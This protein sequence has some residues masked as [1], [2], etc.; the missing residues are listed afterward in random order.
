MP[1]QASTPT[2]FPCSGCGA[3]LEFKPGT[4][5]LVCPHCGS[6]TPI[7]P[8]DTAVEE[9]DYEATL[10]DLTD[11]HDA[12][13]KIVVHCDSCGANVPMEPNVTS[14]ACPFCG[15]NIVATGQSKRLLRPRSLLPFSLGSEQAR[16]RFA[17]WINGLWF[18]PSDLKRLA[19]I[20]RVALASGSTS[21]GTGAGT[22]L[23][24][25]YVPYWTFDSACVTPYTGQRGD[26]YTVPVTYTVSVNGRSQVRTRLETRIR[27]SSASGCV[28]DRF[29][30]VLVP[31]STSLPAD[32]LA[33]LGAWDLKALVPY[34]D[35]YLSGFRAESYTIDLPAGFA[36][37]KVIMIEGIKVTIRRDIGGDHQRIDS[38]SPRFSGITFK[39]ILLPVWISTFRY[40]GT[41]YRFLVNARTG[42]VSGQ[43]PYSAWKITMLVLAILIAVGAI[44]LV[45]SRN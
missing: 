35:R 28:N 22:A 45:A 27:W 39:H 29:D 15:T 5:E 13:D 44:V 41:L 42:Q 21:A 10:R 31:G 2:T 25:M 18:A 43:R 33:A 16:A 32:R 37:A 17:S 7:A 26:N 40:R 3:E 24:G 8:V 36:G 19:S 14:Q 23:V 38:M 20:E 1:D 6:R 34:D 12:E 11:R 4:A 30:D 9:I